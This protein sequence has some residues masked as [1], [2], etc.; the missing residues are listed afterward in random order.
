[1]VVLP[2]PKVS[3]NDGMYHPPMSSSGSR[4]LHNTYIP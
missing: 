1:M 2:S 3:T 4:K